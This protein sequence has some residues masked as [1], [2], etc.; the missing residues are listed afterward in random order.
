MVKDLYHNAI[1]NALVKDGWTIT[2]INSKKPRR[3]NCSH[4]FSKS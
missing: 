2:L 3:V 1:K 4:V